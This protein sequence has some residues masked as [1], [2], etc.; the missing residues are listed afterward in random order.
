MKKKEMTFYGISLLVLVCFHLLIQN[1]YADDI[2]F[3]KIELINI[4]DWLVSRYYT[5]SS[6][7]F[8]EFILV[9]MLK[10]PYIIWCIINSLMMI[11]IS[12]CISYL[13]TKNTFK[14]KFLALLFVCLYPFYKMSGAG[15]YATTLNYLWPMS[16]GLFSFIPIKNALLKKN[17]NKL[18]CV[19][20]SLS[21]IFACNHEQM[22]TLIL[23]FYLLF[24]LF[25][26]KQQKLNKYI[27]FQFLLAFLSIIY[28]LTC[29]GNDARLSSEILS[30]YPEFENFSIIQKCIVGFLSTIS[31][32]ILRLEV[33]FV[34]LLIGNIY[35]LSHDKLLLKLNSYIPIFL[36]VIF[37]TFDFFL[38]RLNIYE[39]KIISFDSSM[40]LI[41]MLSSILI[42]SILI[43]LY[44]IFYKLKG[45]LKFFVPLIFISGLLSRL[46]LTFS[47]TVYAS[48]DRTFI[49][50]DFSI[51]IILILIANNFIKKDMTFLLSIILFILVLLQMLNTVYINLTLF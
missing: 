36:I 51:I 27:L 9:L 43:S 20:Y 14:N 48:G 15:W 46:I 42:I 13:F 10:M 44:F 49:F 38:T 21:I 5:W 40:I 17:N 16:L 50:F 7:I 28:I 34:L 3:E 4:F 12:Y 37:R 22:C 1:F 35:L 6:R 25:L 32:I 33:P 26:Y 30:W 41:I 2:F 18:M 11:L 31:R 39:T 8:I 29:P 19:F 24:I 23:A 47:P 45:N